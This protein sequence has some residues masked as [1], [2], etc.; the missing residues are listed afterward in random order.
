MLYAA[1]D[2][3]TAEGTRADR[4]AFTGILNSAMFPIKMEGSSDTLMGPLAAA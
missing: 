1:T 3:A 2:A 4:A